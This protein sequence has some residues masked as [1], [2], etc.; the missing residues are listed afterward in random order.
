M[1]CY[2]PSAKQS[3]LRSLP[4]SLHLTEIECRDVRAPNEELHVNSNPASG[5]PKARKVEK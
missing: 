2:S 3:I 4:C 1:Q 5:G